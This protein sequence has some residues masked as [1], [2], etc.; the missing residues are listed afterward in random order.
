MISELRDN[1][2]SDKKYY[3]RI[4]KVDNLSHP[5]FILAKK[6]CQEARQILDVGCGD[7]SKLSQLGNEK[8]TRTGCELGEAGIAQ[9]KS[10]FKNIKFVQLT[11][12][13]LPFA[14]GSFDHVASFFVLEHVENPENVISEMIRVLDES[15]LLILLIP[16]YGSPNRS[17]P[18]FVGNRLVKLI[19]GFTGDF[20]NQGVGSWHRVQP[21]SESM[22]NFE[23]D[24]DTTIEPYLG[25]LVLSLKAAKMNVIV[26]NSYW[27]MELPKASVLQRLL[28]MLA[29]L[30]LYPFINWGP[31][32]FVVAKK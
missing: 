24:L 16:N 13:K 9:G 14:D 19:G 15:G 12:E 5:G 26:K 27:E 7:G 29:G 3:E 20:M 1:L 32:A 2:W 8:T 30:H 25:S 23:M 11:D 10:K 31:H 6:Y 18:N 4:S 21:R 28:R 17:S 22:N